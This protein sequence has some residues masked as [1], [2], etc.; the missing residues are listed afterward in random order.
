MAMDYY[1]YVYIYIYLYISKDKKRKKKTEKTKMSKNYVISWS[2]E[3]EQLSSNIKTAATTA[4]FTHNL[5]SDVLEKL[6]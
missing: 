2:K 1:L 5:K 4:S 6:Q 3:L